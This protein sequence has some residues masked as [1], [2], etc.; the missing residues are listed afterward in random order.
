MI[1]QHNVDE[2]FFFLYT[3]LFFYLLFYI[4]PMWQ[5]VAHSY[6]ELN[7][8]ISFFFFLLFRE[9]GMFFLLYAFLFLGEGEPTIENIAAKT[10]CQ[11]N[12][13]KIK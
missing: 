7:V 3:F 8:K 11:L 4:Y 9:R 13:Y 6:T 5:Q 1:K 2:A 12:I 10:L